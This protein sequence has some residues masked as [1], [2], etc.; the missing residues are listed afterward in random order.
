MSFR[1]L[2]AAVLVLAC[3]PA[4]AAVS[5]AAISKAAMSKARP[6]PVKLPVPPMQF[7]VVR[8][9]PDACGRG[10]DSWIAV[11][12][13][14]DSGAA[15][16]F[17][18]FFARVRGRNLPIYFYSPGGSVEQALAMGAVL[19]EKPVVA[20]VG[21]TVV[22]ECGLEAQDGEA[23]LKLKQSGRELHGDI[24]TRGAF[25]GS[26]CPYLILGATTREVAADA[27]LAVHSA[28][29]TVSFRGPG[30]PPAEMVAAANV[31]AHERSDHMIAA[32][33]T[34]MGAGT[35]LLD[36]VRTVKFEEMH[37]LTREEIVRFGIDRR[38]F[39]E[40]PWT[41]EPGTRTMVHKVA[42]QRREGEK[43][44]R[45]IQW[46]VIC[47]DSDSFEL[48]FQRP[49]TPSPAL[50]S[51]SVSGG[52][53]PLSLFH[54]RTKTWDLEIWGARMAKA[55]VQSLSDLP[56]TDFTETVPTADGRKYPLIQKLSN[57]GFANGMNRL[58]ATCPAP[59]APPPQQQTVEAR[60]QAAK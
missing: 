52:G 23:C 1:I 49:A 18:R 20:R 56:Q 55:S 58:L 53:T 22:N 10:C 25:C 21:R 5:K 44:F 47:L 24:S 31:R 35:A 12:G 34:R 30:V 48:D 37:I 41:F 6:A 4:K 36:L 33:L 19:R 7:Y 38:E 40:T 2:L 28:K 60:D 11:E 42:L 16:R 39:V 27:A 9:A 3:G 15:A 45:T 29:V 8:G 32:Y 17:S 13:K 54:S 46:R 57:E 43:S 26:A 59:K 14:I 51:V 50:S